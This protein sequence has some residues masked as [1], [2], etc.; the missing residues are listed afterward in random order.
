MSKQ[1]IISRICPFTL[2]FMLGRIS[3]A[4]SIFGTIVSVVQLMVNR[5]STSNS[6]LSLVAYP[7]LNA[8]LA[9]VAGYIIA[10]I[11]NLH[12]RF[13]G[14]LKISVAEVT[15]SLTYRS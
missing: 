5:S 3:F 9:M 10:R 2:A 11:F 13:F 7:F 15:E 6:V 8:F 12:A 1:H 4:V 14:G